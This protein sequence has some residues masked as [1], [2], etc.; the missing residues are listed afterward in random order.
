LD[1]DKIEGLR[2]QVGDGQDVN[3]YHGDCNQILLKEVFPRVQF[4]EYKRGLGLLDPYKLTLD[5]AVIQEAGSM[6]S[7]DIFIDFPIQDIN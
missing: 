5:W 2:S 4:K 3:F 7:L 6:R 1:G